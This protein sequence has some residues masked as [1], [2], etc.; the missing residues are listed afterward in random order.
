MACVRAHVCGTDLSSKFS[1]RQALIDGRRAISFVIVCSEVNRNFPLEK[2]TAGTKETLSSPQ[3]FLGRPIVHLV[4]AA[5]TTRFV[6]PTYVRTYILRR[7]GQLWHTR[8]HTLTQTRRPPR[9]FI[10]PSPILG[11][12]QGKIF[13]N[14]WSWCHNL[15]I[16]ISRTHNKVWCFM[17]RQAAADGCF[18]PR[19]NNVS[20]GKITGDSLI[21]LLC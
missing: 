21:T 3:L 12:S 10:D 16:S 5:R 14:F 20:L 11:Q 13:A 9:V 8:T 17:R 4:D 18:F 19:G 7:T 6:L 2:K 15:H 1:A